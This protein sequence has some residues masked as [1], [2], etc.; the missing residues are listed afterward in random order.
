[1]RQICNLAIS[2]AEAYSI[3]DPVMSAKVF[4]HFRDCHPL[5]NLI[6][7]PAELPLYEHSLFSAASSETLER[8]KIDVFARAGNDSDLEMATVTAGS[9]WRAGVAEQVLASFCSHRIQRIRR[10]VLQS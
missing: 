1:M 4:L 9:V 3:H 5:L 6:V 7:E 8:L 10:A 2:L